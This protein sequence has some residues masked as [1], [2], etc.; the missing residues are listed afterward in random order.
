M[1][2]PSKNKIIILFTICILV[3]LMLALFIIF[4]SENTYNKEK[5]KFNP[6][7]IYLLI[8]ALFSISIAFFVRFKTYKEGQK[9]AFGTKVWWNNYR[10]FHSIT[11]FLAASFLL[12]SKYYKV[13]YYILIFDILAGISFFT[14]DKVVKY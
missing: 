3:R 4:V 9:G 11:F 13:A 10:L 2:P 8:A 7:F 1:E 14:Y 6:I 5:N 12:S